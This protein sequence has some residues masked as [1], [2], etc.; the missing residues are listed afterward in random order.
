MM[1]P[2]KL[3]IAT[4]R[5]GSIIKGANAGMPSRIGIRISP[6][7]IHHSTPYAVPQAK[8]EG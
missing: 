2:I 4:G 8:P 5:I 7:K 3:P 6:P 1:W